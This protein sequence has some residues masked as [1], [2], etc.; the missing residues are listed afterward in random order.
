MLVIDTD[1]L[2]IHHIFRWDKRASLNEEF[3][4][5]TSE[6]ERGTTIHNL[7]EL[8]GLLSLAGEGVKVHR[9]FK[10][11]LRSKYLILYPKED[12]QKSIEKILHFEVRGLSYG[13]S[14]VAV[15]VEETGADEFV[16]WNKRHF[17]GKISARIMTPEEYLK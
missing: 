4:L 10:D 5:R 6:K 12:F 11:F 15:V 7:L 1:V 2:A 17:E 14:L 8:C 3:L 9:L 16:T 13:D